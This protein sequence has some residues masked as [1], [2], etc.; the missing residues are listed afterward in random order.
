MQVI[1][2]TL[3]DLLADPSLLPDLFLNYDCDTRR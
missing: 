3:C 1:L 2:E